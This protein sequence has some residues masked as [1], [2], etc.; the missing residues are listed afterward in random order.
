MNIQHVDTGNQKHTH[1]NRPSLYIYK[2]LISF[3]RRQF[4][5]V[6]I[7]RK[8]F[9]SFLLLFFIFLFILF[10]HL[11]SFLVLLNLF[12]HTVVISVL[13]ISILVLRVI[14]FDE[15]VFLLSSSSSLL[16]FKILFFTQSKTTQKSSKTE[17]QHK[18]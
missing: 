6:T 14:Y 2:M 1:R 11:L 3:K 17:G 12:I 9:F 10:L 18:C 16:S 15:A 4:E 13:P 7:T 5:E 8:L